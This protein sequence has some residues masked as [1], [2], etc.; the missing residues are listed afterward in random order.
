MTRQRNGWLV[1]AGLGMAL[2]AFWIG[3]AIAILEIV[4]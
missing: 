3:V 1:I 4:Q 2:A